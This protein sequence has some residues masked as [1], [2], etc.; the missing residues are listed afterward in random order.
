MTKITK[1]SALGL[2]LTVVGA[3]ALIVG[4]A[5][6]VLADPPTSPTDRDI[7]AVGSN[8]NQGL[9]NG[10]SN[11]F[12]LNGVTT[13]ATD[14]LSDIASYDAG[15]GTIDP[16]GTTYTRPNGSGDGVKALS[17]AWDPAN[18]VWDGTTLGNGDVTVARSS[19]NPGTV[20]SSSD[21]LAFIPFGRDA[22]GVVTKDL[23]IG[24][25]TTDELEALYGTGAHTDGTYTQVSGT[26]SVG[27]IQ[28]SGS[29]ATQ[30]ELYVTDPATAPASDVQITAALPQSGSG[31]RNFFLTAIG[32]VGGA[33]GAWV[34]APDTAEE[35]SIASVPAD[36]IFPISGASVIEQENGLITNTG[37]NDTG[38][39]FPTIDGSA[40][41]LITEQDANAAPGTLYGNTS[42]V[43]SGAVGVYARDVY[44]VVPTSQLGTVY[45]GDTLQDIF[46]NVLPNLKDASPAHNFVV[47]D[48]GFEHEAPAYTENQSNWF[49]SPFQH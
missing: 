41:T 19:S 47:V 46:D 8:T 40:N 29:G 18:H 17:A 23:N 25:F 33:F 3:G 30:E 38:V 36:G 16:K 26:V 20:Y 49:G 48:Y 1:R 24:N 35:N 28:T 13:N 32:S 22:V 43:P 5:A 6:P 44:T 34:T 9:F 14:P 37:V 2:A 45:D 10:V 15:T 12:T 31:T 4:S 42:V 39:T 7:V 21:D 27:D 11:G